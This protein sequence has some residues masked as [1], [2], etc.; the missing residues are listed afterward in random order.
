MGT[1]LFA[2]GPAAR[3]SPPT[4]PPTAPPSPCKALPFARALPLSLLLP[5]SLT[6]SRCHSIRRHRPR[7]A[8]CL[9]RLALA[10]LPSVAQPHSL[11]LPASLSSPLA[12]PSVPSFGSGSSIRRPCC[13]ARLLASRR[14]LDARQPRPCGRSVTGV[15]RQW[16]S[17]P[18]WPRASTSPAVARP[19]SL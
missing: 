8:P 4:Q 1:P 11:S 16:P 5:S 10:R 3:P 6:V 17:S 19:R 18:L 2:K 9:C 14:S 7:L 15:V 12:A 13:R